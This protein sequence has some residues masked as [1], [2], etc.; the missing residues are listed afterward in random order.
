MFSPQI[1]W[2]E[3]S[4][5]H[6]ILGWFLFCFYF[7]FSSSSSNSSSRKEEGS[8]PSNSFIPSFPRAPST[9]DS[10]RV[11]CR[12]M[13]SAALRTG[14]ELCIQYF[15]FLLFLPSVLVLPLF[16]V[17][18][19]MSD[20]VCILIGQF[21]Q[22]AVSWVTSATWDC[23]ELL[24]CCWWYGTFCGFCSSDILPTVKLHYRKLFP[25]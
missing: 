4:K 25:L 12:E 23:T 14:G 9:S 18:F 2:F 10:V 1:K 7:F 22:D 16:T 11:K 20:C 24:F 5:R 3:E 13:L 8:A 6:L 21:T 15:Q 17:P 19:L